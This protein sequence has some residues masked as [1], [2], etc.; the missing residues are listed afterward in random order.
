MVIAK[1]GTVTI[2]DG[3]SHQAQKA[4]LAMSHT[5]AR[6]QYV[7]CSAAVITGTVAPTAIAP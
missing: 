6:A 3:R 2:C 5:Q 7:R 1:R 4:T